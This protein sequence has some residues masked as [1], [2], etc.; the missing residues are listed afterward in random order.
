MEQEFHS[1]GNGAARDSQTKVGHLLFG[2]L[3]VKLF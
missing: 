1:K 2:K 3:K